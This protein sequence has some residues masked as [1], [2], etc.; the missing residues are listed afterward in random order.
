MLKLYVH[1]VNQLNSKDREGNC[2]LLFKTDLKSKQI[3]KLK[4][5]DVHILYYKQLAYTISLLMW[6]NF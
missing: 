5:Q 4:L 3:V 1:C 6:I 2:I